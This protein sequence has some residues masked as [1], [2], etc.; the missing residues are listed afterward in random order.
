MG[1]KLIFFVTGIA[2]ACMGVAFILKS[3]AG[4]GPQDVVLMV[5]AKKTGVTFGTWVIISQGIF[6]LCNALLLK[7]RP[8]FESV[9]T[10]VLW[11][12]LADFWLEIIFADLH[13]VLVTPVL[14]WSFF[15]L[16]VLLIGI[17]VG[18][19][20]TSEL[21]RMPYDGMMVAL[22]EK[23][24]VNLMVSRTILELLLIFLGIMVGGKVGV[25]TIVIVLCIGTIIQF[26]NQVSLKI[27]HHTF[28][29]KNAF[30]KFS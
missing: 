5:L 6:L 15:L 3:N 27:Y 19:Y 8:Q 4:A 1:K 2:V 18:I 13:F 24:H 9:F 29:F 26:F 23:F 11:G 12:L 17:G 28:D 14:R 7:K 30:K 25:G 10:M 21:P 16:G 20:L 22:S